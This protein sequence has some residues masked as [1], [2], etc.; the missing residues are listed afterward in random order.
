MPS[1][2]WCAFGIW[3]LLGRGAA[4]TGTLSFKFDHRHSQTNIPP[5]AF[6][7]DNLGHVDSMAS[8]FSDEGWRLTNLHWRQG[9]NNGEVV[10]LGGLIS[11]PDFV[12]IFSLGS[13]WLHFQSLAFTTGSGT[14][15]LPGDAALGVM[16]GGWLNE[17]LYIMGGFEDANSL[18]DDPLEGFDTFFNDR[19]YFKH[20]EIGWTT[21]RDRAYLDNFHLTLWHVD[22]REEAGVEDGWGGCLILYTL[23]RR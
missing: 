19:E 9:W 5:N 7:I 6:S 15:S 17:N 21:S 16:V 10:A 4:N 1:A 18:S 12:D 8:T 22:E 20:I 14:I 23:C 13:P 2:A 11:A 3:E